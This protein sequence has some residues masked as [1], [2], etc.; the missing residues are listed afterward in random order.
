M[1][2]LLGHLRVVDRLQQ[3]IAQLSLQL[4][5]VLPLDGVGDFVGLLDR[6]GRD[7]GEILLEY[8]RGS[9]SRGRA[10]AP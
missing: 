1:P 4:G 9:P 8:P 2:R 3:Q 5:P 7:G 10:A 6:V